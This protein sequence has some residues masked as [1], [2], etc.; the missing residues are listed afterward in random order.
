MAELFKACSGQAPTPL[1]EE[2]RALAREAAAQ[3]MVLLKNDGALPLREGRVALY[4]SGARMTVSGGTGS[5]QV[6]VRCTVSIEKGLEEAGFEIA[7]RG[8]LDR[9]DRFYADTYESY[10]QE[11]ERRCEGLRD[12]KAIQRA[13]EPFEHPMGIPILPGDI[14]DCER[15]IYV[16]ARQAGEGHDREVRPGDYLLGE[17]EREN[18]KTLSAAYKKLV[19]VV[20]AGA[21]IDLSFMDELRVD[22]LVYCAQ[23]GEE[24]G[25]ALAD[26]LS[27]RE[28]FS[29]KLSAAW[30]RRYADRPTAG[31]YSRAGGEARRQEYREDIYVGYRYF[32]SFGVAPRFAFGFG[33]SYTRFELAFEGLE[34]EEGRLTLTARVT[35]AGAVPG[36]ETAQLYASVPFGETGAE[37]K[38]LVAFAKT[39]LLAGGESEILALT[40]PLKALACYDGGRSAWV[41]RGG[42]YVLRLGNAC[43]STVPVCTLTLAEEA[44]IEQCRRL[45]APV[46][47]IDALR[48]PARTAE[49]LPGLPSYGLEPCVARC[50]THSY[51]APEAGGSALAA[52]LGRDELVSLVVGGGTGGGGENPV[53][54]LGASGSTT[55]ALWETRGI[56]NVIL[57]DGPAGLN[58]SAQVVE[59]PNGELRAARTP[60]TLSAYRRYLFG[61]NRAAL[62]RRMADPAEG[63]MRYQYAT[64][65]PCARL[66]AQSFDT[67]L[68]E[69][70]GRAVGAEMAAFG[71]S[72]WLAPGMNILRDPLCGRSFEYYSEDPL[73]S[74][75]LAAAVTRGVQS[76]PGRA[77]SLKHFAANSCELERNQSD[78][79]LSERALREIYL[80]GFELAVREGAPLTV[81]AAYNKINGVYCTNSRELLD[82]ILRGEWGFTGLVMSDWDAMKAKAA[83]DCTVPLS[84]DV[85]KAHAAGCDLVMPGRADQREA[86]R[87]GLESGRVDISDL[88]RSAGRVLAL[89]RRTAELPVGE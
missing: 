13:V 19:V 37:Y 18:L 44:V 52:A 25:S 72:V 16:L 57:A 27:G 40:V 58:L 79:V 74:G 53:A 71:V 65:W 20:N 56:P 29:G 60:E 34:R 43:D 68:L 70:V 10:R 21:E 50:V 82:G 26:L 73:L 9:F 30:A 67:A 7:S 45:C 35:N 3:G 64:E 76:R 32:D 88:R 41:L 84:A 86:L 28:N 42:E 63:V 8:W 51:G 48:A 33:L 23:P 36:R 54:A 75:K 12:F 55:G 81:M 38:R 61:F 4:G 6:R 66:L 80:S 15:A 11:M 39:K 5:G 2:N 83:G 49:S 85:Q 47:P 89:I 78:S 1:E 59:L 69:R 62:T 87:L 22:A 46:E 17:V 24:G 14:A 77:V 31:N